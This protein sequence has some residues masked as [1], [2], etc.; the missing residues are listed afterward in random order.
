MTAI[1]QRKLDFNSNSSNK[2]RVEEETPNF[3]GEDDE[4]KVQDDCDQEQLI[5]KFTI[6]PSP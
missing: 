3:R 5:S 1:K 6:S 4:A 2:Q